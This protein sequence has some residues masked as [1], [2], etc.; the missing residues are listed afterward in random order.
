MPLI[1]KEKNTKNNGILSATKP[2]D[3]TLSI[4]Q[5]A[6]NIK[7]QTAQKQ[8]IILNIYVD[9]ENNKIFADASTAYALGVTSVRAIMT[10]TKLYEITNEHIQKY[11]NRLP[12]MDVEFN[13]IILEQK[14]DK[15]KMYYTQENKFYIDYSSSYALGL[16]SDKDFNDYSLQYYGPLAEFEINFIKSK[17]NVELGQITPIE[18]NDSIKEK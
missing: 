15:I 4:N 7:L 8:K 2:Q 13:K 11:K 3:M 9:K 6:E 17:Y 14:K 5:T 1:F 12:N 16:I 10:G 18:K